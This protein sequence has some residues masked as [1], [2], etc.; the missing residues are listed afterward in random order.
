MVETLN[1]FNTKLR[2]QAK[3]DFQKDFFKLMNHSVIGKT[4][5]N[6]RKH[7]DVNLVTNEKAYRGTVMGLNF[8]SYFGE[9][10]MSCEMGKVTVIMN[11]PVYLGQ[12]ILDLSKIV[13]YESHYDYMIPKYSENLKLCY[14]DTDSLVYH[15]E[16]EDSYEVF[17]K[18]WKQNSIRV[19][20]YSLDTC[21]WVK[22]KRSWLPNSLVK[23]RT[24]M[25]M[26]K[27]LAMSHHYYE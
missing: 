7:R 18:M 26:M 16:T 11:K 1:D 17:E 19:D 23:T 5:E 15:I 14:T 3:N 8:K 25:N 9:T 4:M 21:Q 22:T 24:L 27:W 20:L 10:L 12:A 2:A 6:I 13:M